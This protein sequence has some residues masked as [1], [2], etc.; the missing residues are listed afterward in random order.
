ME[1]HM[2]FGGGTAFLSI[3]VAW[4]FG[5]TE[6]TF[7]GLIF[8]WIL[9]TLSAIDYDEMLLPDQLTMPLIWLGLLSSIMPRA[10]ISPIA[11]ILGA[12]L[13]ATVVLGRY[14]S[15]LEANKETINKERF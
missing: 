6:H 14:N 7:L 15:T 3:L 12:V 8:T 13:V 9:I 4:K 11:A 2:D 1:S 10:W 5:V